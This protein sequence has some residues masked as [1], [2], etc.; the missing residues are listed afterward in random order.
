MRLVIRLEG[1][2]RYADIVSTISLI[3]TLLSHFI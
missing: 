3:L 2:V 1:S